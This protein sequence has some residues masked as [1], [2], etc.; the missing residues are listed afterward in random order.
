MSGSA[1]VTAGNDCIKLIESSVTLWNLKTTMYFDDDC[2]CSSG[3][4]PQQQ[5]F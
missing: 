1:V 2:N 3:S 4:R 5:K